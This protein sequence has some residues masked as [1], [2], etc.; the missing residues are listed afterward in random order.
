MSNTIRILPINTLL[1]KESDDI[2]YYISHTKPTNVPSEKDYEEFLL[3]LQKIEMVKIID[4]EC[5]HMIERILNSNLD[6]IIQKMNID[7]I[8]QRRYSQS[9]INSIH[10]DYNILLMRMIS[11]NKDI[12]NYII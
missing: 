7:T 12:T 11:E 3:I 10:Q 5:D 6:Y 8:N 2:N 9:Y 1:L 4:S